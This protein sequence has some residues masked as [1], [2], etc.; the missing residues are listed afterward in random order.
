VAHSHWHH[1]L[2][3]TATLL[4]SPV[5]GECHPMYRTCYL[6][7]SHRS[8]IEM[9]DATATRTLMT[10]NQLI[11]ALS[12]WARGRATD[13]AVSPSGCM[14]CYASRSRSR[15]RSQVSDIYVKLGNEI[16]QF[17]GHFMKQGI[18]ITSVPSPLPARPR[19]ST[20][21]R[22]TLT[23]TLPVHVEN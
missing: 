16:V 2:D 1:E 20:L 22:L 17:H 10:T 6:S 13:D 5:D 8:Q 14:R 4:S 7:R 19:S 15:S 23:P 12:D 11:T 18:N 21:D 9:V 3:H